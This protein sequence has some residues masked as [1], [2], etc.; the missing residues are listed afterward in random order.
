MLKIETLPNGNQVGM[1]YSKLN[2]SIVCEEWAYY[3]G[4]CSLG[5]GL[6]SSKDCVTNAD[7]VPSTCC[8]PTKCTSKVNAPKCNGVACT[9]SCESILDCNQ[10]SCE[11]LNGK[12]NVVVTIQKNESTQILA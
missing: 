4:E 10:A 2:S 9:L 12:C 8:H 5:S 3:N 11:C 6:S 7:C 1:C